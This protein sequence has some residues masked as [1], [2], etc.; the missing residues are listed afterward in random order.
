MKEGDTLNRIGGDV[1]G[2]QRLDVGGSA[3]RAVVR[4]TLLVCIL[5][6]K[7]FREIVCRGE[8]CRRRLRR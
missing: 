5:S 3:D 2:I 1:V 8:R 6:R 7:D 4:L